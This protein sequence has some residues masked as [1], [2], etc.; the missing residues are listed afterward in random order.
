MGNRGLLRSMVLFAGLFLLCGTLRVLTYHRDLCECFSQLFCAAMLLFWSIRVWNRVTDRR[1]RR[2]I[3]SAAGSLLLFLLLQMFR[4]CLTFDKLTYQRYLWYGYYIPYITTP[5]LLFLCALAVYRP[6]E[7]PLPRWSRPV[8]AVTAALAL[9]ALTNDLHQWMFRFPG[10]VFVDADH[11]SPGLAFWLYF[12]CYGALLLAGFIIALRK[13][14][15]IRRG[16]SFLIPL[17]PP[18]LLGVWMIQNLL[19]AAPAVGGVKIW[20]ESDCF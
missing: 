13:A 9:C 10:G 16:L 17:L 15:K 1:L 3:L 12:A 18:L 6:R 4:G 11:Y 20:V 5:L 2:L 7:E 14:W 8:A 19:H